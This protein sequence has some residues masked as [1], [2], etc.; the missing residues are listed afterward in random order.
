MKS[1][2]LIAG[3]VFCLLAAIQHFHIAP[4]LNRLPADYA[5]ETSY[6]VASQFRATLTSA[7]EKIEMTS[8]RV[9]Q[10][11]VTTKTRSIIQGDLHWTDSSG[12]VV[13]ETSGI[14]GVDRYRRTNL[15]GY[16]DNRRHGQFMFP[17]HTQPGGDY[18]YWDPLFIGPR[19]AS[20]Q[21]SETIDG[22]P[23]YIFNFSGSGM[24]ESAGYSH[25]QDVPERY[26]ALTDGEG[27]LWIEPVSGII[28]DYEEKG[29][30]YFAE[31]TTQK[32][33]AEIHIWSDYYT[34]D[35]RAAKWQQARSA[36]FRILLWESWLPSGL[37]ITGL[38]LVLT[39][40]WRQRHQ[41]LPPRGH[42]APVATRGS[43]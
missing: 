19:I 6:S 27:T 20:Y 33:V 40:W 28:V 5:D 37:L 22:M 23:V 39:H 3:F 32:K 14:Y 18:H 11:L 26:R 16:G 1:H 35:T 41:G 4:L 8:R 9:D 24:D 15:P 30:S 43:T 10:T 7:W 29:H 12:T 2:F 21:R 34:P 13:F 17:V 38:A 31:P 25:L 36:R 42:G